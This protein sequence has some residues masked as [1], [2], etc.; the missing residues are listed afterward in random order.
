MTDSN[1]ILVNFTTIPPFYDLS[2]DYTSTGSEAYDASNNSFPTTLG[3][4]HVTSNLGD[5]TFTATS[6]PEPTTLVSASIACL[7]TGV[8]ILER[9]R[10]VR[11]PV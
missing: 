10:C 5:A 9:Q 8:W 1:G 6:V 3:T 11:R 2:T 7:M 4:L